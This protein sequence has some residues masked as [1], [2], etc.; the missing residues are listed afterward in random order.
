MTV[1]PKF[2]DS[3]T[4]IPNIILID[5][6]VNIEAKYIYFCMQAIRQFYKKHDIEE[7]ELMML[8]KKHGMIKQD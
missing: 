6:R 7:E 4:K 2:E 5:D 3:I 1:E 8:L